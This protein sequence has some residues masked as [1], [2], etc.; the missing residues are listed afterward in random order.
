MDRSLDDLFFMQRAKSTTTTAGA[1][2]VV[3]KP[4]NLPSI[5]KASAVEC[6]ARVQLLAACT[7]TA[8][9]LH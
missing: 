8:A 7:V 2:L 4:V 5:K 6:A 9:N 3:P 1:K